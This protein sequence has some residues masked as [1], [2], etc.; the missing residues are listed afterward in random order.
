MA[1]S[2]ALPRRAPPTRLLPLLLFVGLLVSL[3]VLVPVGALGQEVTL[4]VDP[5]TGALEL[6][7]GG[8][9]EEER[10]RDA[11]EEG[12][13]LRIRVQAELWRD[14]LF[15]SQEGGA[16][17]RATVL[18]DPLSRTYRFRTTEL[19]TEQV[20]VSLEQLRL[21]V[22]ESFSLP[23]RPSRR[24]RYYYLATLD[25]E[26]FSLSDL[27]ELQRWLRGDLGPG[28]AGERGGVDGALTRGVGRLLQRALG[29]PTLRVRLQSPPFDFQGEEEEGGGQD[30]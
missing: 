6:R 13:P 27:E 30:D 21:V 14:G 11:L 15:D 23:L 20:L 28:L 12:L 3:G 4:A 17:W 1:I 8:L 5:R 7:V 2:P 24:A 18:Y 22:L 29:L 16:E 19:A 9:L 25:V 10:F 26:T